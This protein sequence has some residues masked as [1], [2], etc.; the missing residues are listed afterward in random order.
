[1]K[2]VDQIDALL[3]LF[4]TVLFYLVFSFRDLTK[5]AFQIDEHVQ[6][7]GL[8]LSEQAFK[9]GATALLPFF[10]ETVAQFNVTPETLSEYTI[11]DGSMV[12]MVYQNLV[13]A[14]TLNNPI[15]YLVIDVGIVVSIIICVYLYAVKSGIN[16]D[17]TFKTFSNKRYFLVLLFPAMAAVIFAI[18]IGLLNYIW[19]I[20]Y[21]G[22]EMS[23]AGVLLGFFILIVIMPFIG[24]LTHGCGC[25][26]DSPLEDNANDTEL[27]TR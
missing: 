9:E 10:Y 6:N 20:C 14:I 24:C 27:A 19:S 12:D 16:E 15:P 11:G 22:S 8:Q 4:T 1:V 5:P 18:F 13:C 21:T 23:V 3:L 25:V 17:E 7:I 26:P 2:V